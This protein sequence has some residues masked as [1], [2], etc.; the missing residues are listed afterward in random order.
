MESQLS[1]EVYLCPD[2][3]H[4]YGSSS[5]ARLE[6]EVVYGRVEDK[7]LGKIDREAKG[8]RADCPQC[9]TRRIRRKAVVLPL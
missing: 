3:G 9:G 6:N 4:Y 1:V 2:C 5:M 7:K 8:T